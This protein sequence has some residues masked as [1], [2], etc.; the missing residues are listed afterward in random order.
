MLERWANAGATA[1]AGVS[2]TTRP[3]DAIVFDLGGV[4]IE[5]DPRRLYR[6][7]FDDE[8][9]MEAFLAEV[10]TPAWNARQDAGR[11]WP[12]AIESLLREHPEARDLI[13]AYDER[14]EEMLG[15]AFPETV[16]LLDEL[17]RAGVPCYAL[18]NWSS[19]K[20][21]VAR[22]HYP[23]LEWFAGMVI[24]GEEGVAKPDPAIYRIMLARFG[25]TPEATVFIDDLDTNVAV[26]ARLGMI[27]I[28]FRDAVRLRRDLGFLGL[29]VAPVAHG[30][31]R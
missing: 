21:A 2:V 30:A 17:R 23:F 4:L 31:N 22:G 13:V 19:E 27:A 28:P 3:V 25:L 9:A 12:G 26:A 20:F 14:W 24:S 16:A 10:C 11:P 29:P 6:K 1:G 8:A 15:D 7:L 5:W 18:S